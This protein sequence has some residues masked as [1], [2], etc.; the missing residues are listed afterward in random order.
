MKAIIPAAGF[1]TRMRPLTFTRPKPVLNVA[2]KPIIVHATETLLAAGIHE[3]GIVVSKITRSAVQQAVEDVPSVSITFLEQEQMLGLGHAVLMGREWVGQDDVCVY[4]GDNLFENGVGD[5]VETFL[6]ERPS[7]VIGLAEVEDPRAF[8]VAQLDGNRIIE[9]IEKPA[10]PPSN[11]A[12]AGVYC[13]SPEIFKQLSQLKPST[14][15]EYEITDAI[16]GLIEAGKTVLGETVRGWWKD[17]GQPRD[18]IEANHLLL[19][20]LETDVQGTVEDSRVSGRVVL[21]ASAVVRHSKIVGPAMIGEGVVIERAYIGPFTSIGA[22]SVI[23]NAEVEHSV[24]ER[25]CV[26]EDVETRLQDCL[27]GLRAVV[28]GGRRV[29]KTLKLTLSD[30]SIV[31]LT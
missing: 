30:E 25:E 27:I 9:L 28:R 29:P 8:G 15:G 13:F 31:E 26:I 11:L 4:L 10:D 6:R 12:V 19:E 17:T 24:I 7:A 5:F 3:I 20:R 14:R 22:G 2:G 21:A 1:G 23:R 16:Q 18:L